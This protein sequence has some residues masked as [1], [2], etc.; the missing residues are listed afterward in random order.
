MTGLVKRTAATM[1]L[2]AIFCLLVVV[3]V[4]PLAAQMRFAAA[5]ELVRHYKWSQAE[6][7]FRDA[8]KMDPFNAS[9]YAGLGSFILAQS[10]YQAHKEPMLKAAKA[11]LAKAVELDPR[12]AGYWVDLGRVEM[13]GKSYGKAFSYFRKAAEKDPNGFNVAYAIGTAGL[14]AWNNIGEGERTLTVD[15]LKAALTSRPSPDVYAAAWS[16]RK[17]IGMLRAMTP[18]T[19][20]GQRWLYDFITSRNLWQYRKAQAEA[21]GSY[22]ERE[23]PG[24]LS[25]EKKAREVRLGKVKEAYNRR[26]DRK[27]GIAASDWSGHTPDLKFRYENGNMYWSGTMDAAVEMP[28]GDV[29][30]KIRAKG[31]P[32]GRIYPYMIVELDGEE[33]GETLVDSADWKDYDF[34]INTA[35]GVKVLSVTFANDNC[36]E[37]EDRN[38]Y[39]GNAEVEAK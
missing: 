33:I 15:R 1:A 32:A 30:I 3:L 21:L 2:T 14:T 8:I 16:A 4:I 5:E 23:R 36:I 38:L 10:G 13:A 12:D 37:K 31:Q 6:A 20:D 17:D 7:Q 9:Y 26:A 28:K 34:R 29:A 35:G 19:L 27:P 18:D 24:E 39:V 22:M 25:D 11:Y